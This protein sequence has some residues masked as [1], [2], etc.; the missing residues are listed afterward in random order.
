M[1]QETRTI[2]LGGRAY[3]VEEV[4]V[5]EKPSYWIVDSPAT[6]HI[7]IPRDG[8]W[9]FN[10]DYAR[11]TFTPSVNETWGKEG[12][13]WEEFKRD[14]RPNRNHCWIRDGRIEYL[15]DSTHSMAGTTVEIPPLGAA[16]VAQCYPESVDEAS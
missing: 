1:S 2:L 13:E 6:G 8:R 16:R 14:P 7:L 5:T 3:P 11:P 15:S 10:D 12:Q 9:T 4:R